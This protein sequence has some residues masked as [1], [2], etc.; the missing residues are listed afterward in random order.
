MKIGTIKWDND[1]SVGNTIVDQQHLRLLTI[2]N[3][4]LENLNQHLDSEAVSNTL[5]EITEYAIMHFQE[6][7]QLMKRSNY[8]ELNKHKKVH[9]KYMEKNVQLCF[10][11][12]TSVEELHVVVKKHLFDWWYNHILH[13]DIKY[14][15]YVSML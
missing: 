3:D 2:I 14:K 5:T 1:F 11:A 4:F 15:S 8:P 7:E 10:A 9:Q 12:M 6:E 13:T